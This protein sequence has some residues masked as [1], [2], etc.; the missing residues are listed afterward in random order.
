MRV[1]EQ[2]S[3][4]SCKFHGCF[5]GRGLSD[6]RDSVQKLCFGSLG[7]GLV[8]GLCLQGSLS[9]SLC[10]NELETRPLNE[11]PSNA[12][13]KLDTSRNTYK[14]H[15]SPCRRLSR[16]NTC[17]ECKTHWTSAR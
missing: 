3:R 8:H 6:D 13:F 11:R 14:T 12:S 9:H 10:S 1:V 7:C 5:H 15:T 4:E 2:L 17:F 16:Q